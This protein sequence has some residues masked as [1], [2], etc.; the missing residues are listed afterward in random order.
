MCNLSIVQ[1]KYWDSMWHM[2]TMSWWMDTLANTFPGSI[3]K[4]NLKRKTGLRWF[5]SLNPQGLACGPWWHERHD[6]SCVWNMS[7]GRRTMAQTTHG[8]SWPGAAV[9]RPANLVQPQWLCRQYQK[10][11]V[12]FWI[13]VALQPGFLELMKNHLD[14][15][16]NKLYVYKFFMAPQTC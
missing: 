14:H 8:Q 1:W 11:T 13:L 12:V 10:Y 15:S 3:D 4:K 2:E 16:W 7:T 5:E 9:L 6:A